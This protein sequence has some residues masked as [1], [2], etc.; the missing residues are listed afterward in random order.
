MKAKPKLS[1]WQIWNLSF[2][3]LGV[4]FGFALQNAN[5][6]R[7]L[8]SIGAD[9]H[10]LSFFWLVAPIMGLIVQPVVGA[11]SDRT[12]TK[13]GRRRPYIFFGALVSMLAMFLMPNAPL[14]IKGAGALFFGVTMLA[15]MDASFN[16]TFQ[17]FRALVADMTPEDQRNVGYSIQS[18]LINVGAVLGSILPFILTVT[19]VENVPEAGKV[20]PSVIWSF[21]IGGSLLLLSVLVTVFKTKEHPPKEFEE[22]NDITE[23]DKAQKESFWKL[24]KK[25]PKTMK[26]L[27]IV[28]LFSWFPLFLLW[29][30]STTAISQHYFGVP[31]GFNAE[32]ETNDSILKAYN[33]AG[34]WVGICFGMYSLIAALFSII[35]PRFIKI[36]SR[37]FVYAASLLLGGL[38]FVSTYFFKDQY[39]LLISMVGIGIAWA[40][41]LAMP[42]AILSGSL[43]AKRMGIYMGLFNLT[44]VIPQILSG[45]IG[46][47]ILRNLFG[48]EG[49]LILVMA[50]V[51][52]ILGALSVSFVKDV[53]AESNNKGGIS[54]GH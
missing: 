14:I 44:V 30:Y 39:M 51:I 20:A 49:I 54:S 47:P 5:A 11:A 29:V 48:G 12:W 43:P 10:E 53:S 28:Q 7:I 23:E 6:S 15:L 25:M 22:Y 37:K 9:P 26:Q 8:S 35:M 27:S 18:F 2:G 21:Y 36:T 24:L 45:V 3:F 17:P 1:F 41:I 42:Y 16:V 38:G 4:Q 40:G 13:L 46:G 52:M 50:G 31:I 32:H 33:T 34:N 19:G